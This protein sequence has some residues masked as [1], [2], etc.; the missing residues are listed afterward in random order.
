MAAALA[1]ALGA[2]GAQQP[3]TMSLLGDPLY[4]PR[5]A[6]GDRADAEAAL[7]RAHEAYLAK[8]SGPAEILALHQAH[9]ALGRIGDALVLLTHGL[10]ANPDEPSLLHERGRDYILIRKFEPA[11]R[12]L[13]KAVEK[14]PEARCALGLAQYLAGDYAQARK[15]YAD[16][17]D[18]GVFGYLADRRGGGTPSTRPVPH[19][20][21]P[22]T[23][24]PL[25]F[26]GAVRRAQGTA[27]PIAASYL[28]AVERLLGG[29]E[30]DA[31]ER[32][33]KIVEKNRG[34]WMDPAYIAAEADYARLKKPERRKK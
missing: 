26:P 34:D 4:P 20:P 32:L 23:P 9:L 15:S 10:E 3:E 30:A 25:T 13:R 19:G 24:P 11:A 6:K 22:S 14:V 27:E 17:R 28:A 18:P 2:A 7:A 8:P 1:L 31:R 12:D 33:K 21:A 5:L 29:D 16:C